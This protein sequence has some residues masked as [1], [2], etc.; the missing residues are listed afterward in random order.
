M[1]LGDTQN[2][3]TFEAILRLFKPVYELLLEEEMLVIA[4]SPNFRPEFDGQLTDPGV[5]ILFNLKGKLSYHLA[6]KGPITHSCNGVAVK[7]SGTAPLFVVDLLVGF[8]AMGEK[9]HERS[10]TTRLAVVLGG[11]TAPENHQE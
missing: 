7:V 6:L 11:K 10:P 3:E 5:S 1:L 8:I 4:T 9:E 2:K